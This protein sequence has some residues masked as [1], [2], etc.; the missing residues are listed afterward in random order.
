[1]N[2]DRVQTTAI[3]LST[4]E[5][6]V[7]LRRALGVTA[8]GLNQITLQP[9]Q[10]GRIHR[11]ERQDEVYLVLD[12]RL[13]LIVEADEEIEL[14]AGML[15]HVPAD[16]RRQLVNPFSAPCTLVAI[17]AA[18]EHEG[19]DGQAFA[20]WSETEGRPPQEVPLPEDLP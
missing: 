10:R 17:G 13:M 1:M 15:A 8:L 4:P 12:G 2:A 5:R 3:D 14:G 11:H 20:D 6:F 18:G 16:V 7:S 9:G 19:R